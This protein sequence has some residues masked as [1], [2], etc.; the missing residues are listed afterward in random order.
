M[1][2]ILA[3]LYGLEF[4]FC[5]A[6]EL[7][8]REVVPKWGLKALDEALSVTKAEDIEILFFYDHEM[9]CRLVEEYIT[10]N[11]NSASSGSPSQSHQSVVDKHMRKMALKIYKN[12]HFKHY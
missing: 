5:L 2:M 6:K 11:N 7:A 8:G 9:A 12:P 1:N 3:K 10:L 4:Y